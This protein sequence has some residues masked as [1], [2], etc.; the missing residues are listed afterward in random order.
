M[1]AKQVLEIALST[2]QILLSNGAEAYRVEETIERICDSYNLECECMVTAKGVLISLL[3][4][5]DEKI[6]SL[7]KIR[8]RRVDLYRIEL[9]NSFSRNLQHKP[10]SYEEAKQ[11]LKEIDEAPY[12][13]FPVR[14]FAASMTSFVYSL[15]FNGTIYDSIVSALVSIGIYY[16]LEKI[17][18]VGFFQFFEFFLS[19]FII[20]GSSII[21]Q[22]LLP[23]VSKGNVITGAIMILLPGVA[24]TNG[25]KDVIYGDFESGMAKFGEAMLI[26]TAIGVGIGAALAIGVGVK[27]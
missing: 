20:G 25:I 8:I 23:F 12:F 14:L 1:E 19:G 18:K 24:L 3:D 26:I 11:V 16:M 27:L 22:K 13:S 7:K 4:G 5:N 6:T 2:G 17:S 21:A 15:F 10:M 9:I